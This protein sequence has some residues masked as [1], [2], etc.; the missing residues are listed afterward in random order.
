MKF[1][2]KISDTLKNKSL[3][4]RQSTLEKRRKT[5]NKRPNLKC[6]H[7]SIQSKS[8]VNMRRYHF[9]KCRFREV[10]T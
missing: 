8:S 9:D 5:L 7:C 6:P 1:T 3:D 10:K 4:E 2:K